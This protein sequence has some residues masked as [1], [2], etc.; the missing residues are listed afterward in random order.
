MGLPVQ[1]IMPSFTVHVLGPQL[2]LCQP[3]KFLPLKSGLKF[4]AAVTAPAH[5]KAPMRIKQRDFIK[6]AGASLISGF[7]KFR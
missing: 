3:S 5:A 7:G 6:I 2:T 4:S 1:W